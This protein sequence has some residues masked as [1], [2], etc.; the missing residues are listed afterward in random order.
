MKTTVWMQVR[1]FVA[2]KLLLLSQDS[3]MENC[4]R[5]M[6]VNKGYGT[7]PTTPTTYLCQPNRSAQVTSAGRII[8]EG[9]R[10]RKA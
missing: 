5:A 6:C 3:V 4:I 7:Y 9:R 8:N 2:V 1:P 10:D